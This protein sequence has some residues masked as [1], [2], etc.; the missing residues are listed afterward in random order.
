MYAVRILIRGPEIS[1]HL[2]GR[3]RGLNEQPRS[4]DLP[5]GAIA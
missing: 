5:E 1:S 2:D 4:R 3:L